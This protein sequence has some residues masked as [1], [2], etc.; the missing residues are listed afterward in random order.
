MAHLQLGGDPLFELKLDRG[1]KLTARLRLLSGDRYARLQAADR[2]VH[3]C[4]LRGHSQPCRNRA[5]FGCLI[6]RASS[7]PPS[8]QPAEHVDLPT[9]TEVGLVV[10]AIAVEVARGAEQLPQRGFNRLVGSCSIRA[11]IGR[12]KQGCI[13]QAQRGAR[14]GDACRCL[15]D[16]QILFESQG[17]EARQ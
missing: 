12:R 2:D 17:D 4:R 6:L 9:C 8:T 7:F 11:H 5:G 10:A 3:I 13:C 1:E 15:R 16:V 14:L